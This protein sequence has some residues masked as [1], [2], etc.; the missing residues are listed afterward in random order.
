MRLSYAAAAFAFLAVACAKGD[1]Q[2]CAACPLVVPGTDIVVPADYPQGGKL[3]FSMRVAGFAS[4]QLWAPPAP[5]AVAMVGDSITEGGDWDRLLPGARTV[6]FGVSWDQT[7]GLYNRLGQIAAAQPSKIVLLIGTNDIGNGRPG[8][9]TAEHAA[10]VVEAMTQI[11]PPERILVQ[12]VMPR[13]AQFRAEIETLNARL[14]DI[15]AE[16]GADFIDLYTPFLVDGALDPAVTND[17][18][19]LNEEGYR[20]WAGLIAA[21]A[22]E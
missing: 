1:A 19:H 21:W 12:A 17:S 10:R 18:L 6:N 16:T 8:E 3:H 2:D 4:R 22:A 20:R 15:A 14:E 11:V 9:K 5:G 13:Q 7:T